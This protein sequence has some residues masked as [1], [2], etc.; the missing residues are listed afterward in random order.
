MQTSQQITQYRSVLRDL[1]QFGLDPHDWVEKPA[2]SHDPSATIESIEFAH[3]DDHEIRL[4]GAV[5]NRTPNQ[6]RQILYL[7]LQMHAEQE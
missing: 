5:T 3:R 6:S 1:V 4:I 7:E 2:R